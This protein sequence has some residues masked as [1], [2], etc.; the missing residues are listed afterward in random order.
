MWLALSASLAAVD[1]LEK[2]VPHLDHRPPDLPPGQASVPGLGP[3]MTMA[4][5]SIDLARHMQHA[6]LGICGSMPQGE[7][8]L[9]GS[10]G[11]HRDKAHLYKMECR[12]SAQRLV[13]MVEQWRPGPAELATL[14]I[15]LINTR[16]PA[17]NDRPWPAPGSHCLVCGFL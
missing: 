16:D 14:A 4:S 6:W 5:I 12:E 10:S 8:A 1:D 9:A 2:L 13:P 11:S 15:S 7:C 3:G 17:A